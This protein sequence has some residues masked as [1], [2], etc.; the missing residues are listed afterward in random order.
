MSDAIDARAAAEETVSHKMRRLIVALLVFGSIGTIV[1]L[2][3]LEHTEDFWQ[4]TPV[5]L[6]GITSLLLLVVHLRPTRRLIQTVRVLMT[7]LVVN[8]ALGVYLH[9]VGN[10]EFE[11]EMY[12]SMAGFE[13]FWEALK[14]ATPTLAPGAIALLGLVGLVF[15]YRHPVLRSISW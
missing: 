11:K 13:L 10:I 4:W 8:G 12:P 2:L 6:L 1:E 7:V 15:C 14:G 5:A 9:L 3:L